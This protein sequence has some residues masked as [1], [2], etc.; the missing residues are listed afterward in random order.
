MSKVTAKTPTKGKIMEHPS[1]RDG[2]KHSDDS[3]SKNEPPAAQTSREF[4]IPKRKRTKTK[5]SRHAR[6]RKH[7]KFYQ[8][9]SP[10]SG[11]S[12]SS[13]SFSNSDSELSSNASEKRASGSGG[14]DEVI[15]S[16]PAEILDFASEAVFSGLSKSAR[17]NL[18]KETPVPALPELQPKKVDAFIKKYLKRKGTNF[19]PIMD[20]RQLNLAGRIVDPVGP[21]CHLW[22]LALQADQ[23]GCELPP[24][25]VVDALKRAV[26]L[27]G[28]ASFCAMNDRRKGLLAKIAPDCLDLLDDTTLFTK[29]C[30]DLFGKK[31]K[32]H[33]L[34]DLKL[35]KEIDNLMPQRWQTSA[36]QPNTRRFQANRFFR[37]QPGKGPGFRSNPIHF[38]R[39]DSKPRRNHQPRQHQDQNN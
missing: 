25:V 37:Q 31:F 12:S 35:G 20:R 1:Q 29:D 27:V 17:K 18:L 34:K 19:N 9:S 14:K 30:Q 22:A 24:S 10:S 3:S 28:N 2:G 23:N 32:K 13:S 39:W 16:F 8:D 38:K 33:L 15:D 21:L 6:K 4:K 11:E 7:S 36:T 26:A 5:R